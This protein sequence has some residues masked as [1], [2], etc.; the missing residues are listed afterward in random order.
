[1][2]SIFSSFDFLCAELFR[3]KVKAQLPPAVS[4]VA[5]GNPSPLQ[6]ESKSGNAT[7]QMKWKHGKERFPRFALELDGIHCFET[8]VSH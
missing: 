3:L 2:N 7:E 4:T 5:G 6:H 8:I 1:M